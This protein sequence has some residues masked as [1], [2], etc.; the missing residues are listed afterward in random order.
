MNWPDPSSTPGDTSVRP[1]P[2][3]CRVSAA[4][5]KERGPKLTQAS[6][7]LTCVPVIR[8]EGIDQVGRLPSRQQVNTNLRQR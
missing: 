2:A 5:R 6:N 8:L 3:H 4:P 1:R 7:V